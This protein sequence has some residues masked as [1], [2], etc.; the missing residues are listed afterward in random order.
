MGDGALI[1][2]NSI[3]YT[4]DRAIGVFGQTDAVI[5]NNTIDNAAGDGITIGWEAEPVGRVIVRHNTVR[6]SGT[7]INIAGL[8]AD[9]VLERNVL[10]GNSVG[11]SIQRSNARIAENRIHDS[12]IAIAVRDGAPV[13]AGNILCGN[14]TDLTVPDGSTLSL[15]GNEASATCESAGPATSTPP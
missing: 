10:V 8:D 9:P 2:G 4:A 5:E 12:V 14:G 6:A 15:V 13:L 3:S 7:G 11:I 1:S